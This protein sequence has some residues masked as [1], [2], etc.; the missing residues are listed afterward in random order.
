[1][2]RG[3]PCGRTMSHGLQIRTRHRAR[4]ER[5]ESRPRHLLALFY[6]GLAG[7]FFAAVFFAA[8]VFAAV[9]FAA[10]LLTG[11]FFAGAVFAGALADDVEVLAL[12]LDE[13]AEDAADEPPADDAPEDDP[14]E[15]DDARPDEPPPRAVERPPCFNA[16]DIPDSALPTSV[17]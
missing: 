7:A 5:G 6:R 12:P 2:V 13:P 4:I 17:A 10:V 14:E 3:S 8:V 15:A 16:S 11:A 9:V 1:M